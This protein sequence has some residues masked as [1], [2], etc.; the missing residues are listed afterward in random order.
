MLNI[1]AV[2]GR[3]AADPELKHTPGGVAVTSF[4]LAVDRNY[5]KPGEERQ[6]DWID[7]VA[8]RGTA[9][10][11]CKYFT[12][13]RMIAVS[14]FLQTRVW[15]DRYGAKHKAVELVA[16]QVSFCGDKPREADGQDSTGKSRESLKAAHYEESPKD[17]SQGNLND[18]E[19]IDD[20]DLPF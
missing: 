19:E 16:Q 12:K 3:L 10:F 17:F 7:V 1:A 4:S 5:A 14:G 9:E 11:I 15:E 6:T 18:F 20:S 13:G 8:W 2:M